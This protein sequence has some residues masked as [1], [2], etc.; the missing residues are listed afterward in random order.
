MRQ[1]SDPVTWGATF[2]DYEGSKIG[3]IYRRERFTLP[4]LESIAWKAA[5]LSRVAQQLH[6]L[7]NAMG[8][9]P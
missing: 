9:L 4:E 3:A 5:R 7:L 2:I 6:D 8:V 1:T